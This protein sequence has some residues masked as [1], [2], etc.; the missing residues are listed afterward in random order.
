MKNIGLFGGSFNPIHNGHVQIG[1]TMRAEMGLDEV[2]YM[3]SPQNPWKKNAD[4]CDEQLRLKMVR[5]ALREEVGLVASDYEFHLSR[6]SFTWSTLQSL[7]HDYPDTL[8][9]LII[10]GDN[11][12]Q[13][14][15]WRNA[16]DI[17]RTCR[18]AV[19]PRKGC[20][21]PNPPDSNVRIV[22]VP[23]IDINSTMLRRMLRDGDDITPYV[24]QN[25]I[26]MAQRYYR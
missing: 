20:V 1:R 12:E 25:I 11:W 7:R 6:P 18:I 9:T 4:L 23:L 5:E 8:F 2:W 21:I 26:E 17:R 16:D 13:F 14:D 3:V 24:P 19:F 22:N 15:K 10:G